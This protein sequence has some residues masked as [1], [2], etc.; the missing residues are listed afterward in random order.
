MQPEERKAEI[1]RLLLEAKEQLYNAKC[2]ADGDNWQGFQAMISKIRWTVGCAGTH[3]RRIENPLS[4]KVF[5]FTGSLEFM[6][7]TAAEVAVRNK[8]GT[9]SHNVHRAV[10]Y[11]VLGENPGARH[12]EAQAMGLNIITERQFYALLGLEAS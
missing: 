2:A 12:V 6:D 3:G 4:D 9:V 1:D 7:R 11:V 10:D 5:A 8:G